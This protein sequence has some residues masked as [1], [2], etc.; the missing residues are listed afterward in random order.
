MYKRRPQ[1]FETM[2]PLLHLKNPVKTPT[3]QIDNLVFSYQVPNQAVNT[4]G[5][6]SIRK[7]QKARPKSAPR[8]TR[9]IRLRGIVQT[10]V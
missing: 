4:V 10:D 9:K 7:F 1:K 3:V 6:D 5:C 2:S 8:T